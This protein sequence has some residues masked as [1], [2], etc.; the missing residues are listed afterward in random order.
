MAKKKIDYSQIRNKQVAGI[1]KALEDTLIPTAHET[2]IKYIKTLE[3]GNERKE[4]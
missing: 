2:L 1:L 4:T 3:A